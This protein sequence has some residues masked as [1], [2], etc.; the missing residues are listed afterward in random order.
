MLYAGLPKAVVADIVRNG[1]DER[2]AGAN[3]G[4][5]FGAGSYFA[6]DIEKADQYNGAVDHAYGE[7]DLQSLHK[8]LYPEKDHPGDVRTMLYLS[9]TMAVLTVVVCP[10]PGGVRSGLS[11]DPRLCNP[12][13]GPSQTQC[14]PSNQCVLQVSTWNELRQPKPSKSAAHA[15]SSHQPMHSHGYR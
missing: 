15:A 6:Q 13:K 11:R 4:T 2:Y 10:V 3:K 7:S 12:H 14:E 5:L 9:S 1:F 8:R